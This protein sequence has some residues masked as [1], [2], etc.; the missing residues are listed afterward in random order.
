M[1]DKDDTQAEGGAGK[2]TLTL[3]GAPN[4]AGRTGASRSTH[5]VV[6]EKRTRRVG[7][8]PG[9]N[10]PQQGS[11]GHSRP[12]RSGGSSGG[13]PAQSMGLT[14]NEATARERALR[15]ASARMADDAERLAA[16]E[17]RR[18]EEDARRRA[19]REEA[20]RKEAEANVVAGPPAAK[21]AKAEADPANF[22]PAPPH[23]RLMMKTDVRAGPLRAR[24]AGWWIATNSSAPAA[25]P[26]PRPNA[27]RARLV[28][29]AIAAA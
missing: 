14:A 8:P 25:L 10:R 28:T 19:I 27:R 23:R 4:L 3:K 1:S 7:P 26:V 18:D 24:P 17:R 21:P 16:E 5:N 15:E 2:K 20:E 6:V 13:R 12:Q 11:G 9:S 29:N 22:E